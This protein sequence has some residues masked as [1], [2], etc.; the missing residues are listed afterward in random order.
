MKFRGLGCCAS[1][2]DWGSFDVASWRRCS[3][4]CL[5]GTVDSENHSSPR[6]YSKISLIIDLILFSKWSNA[7]LAAFRGLSMKKSSWTSWNFAISAASRRALSRSKKS[8]IFSLLNWLSSSLV[9]RYLMLIRPLG[10]DISGALIFF[11]NPTVEMY[12]R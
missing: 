12:Q 8:T 3:T 5:A 6:W 9:G 10:A 2:I 11:L 1:L 7:S 4:S